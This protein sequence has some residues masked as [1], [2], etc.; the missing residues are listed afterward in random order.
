MGT[1]RTELIA[2]ISRAMEAA[3]ERDFLITWDRMAEESV[4]D[5]MALAEAAVDELPKSGDH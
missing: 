5:W 1:D 4:V 2:R 3:H